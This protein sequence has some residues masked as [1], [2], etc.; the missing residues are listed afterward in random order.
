MPTTTNKA[1]ALLM[2]SGYSGGNVTAYLRREGDCSSTVSGYIGHDWTDDIGPD[3]FGLDAR[4]MSDNDRIDL[5]IGGPMPNV[6]LPPGTMS[7]P[8]EGGYKPYNGAAR[9]LDYVSLDV[10]LSLWEAKGAIVH[11]EPAAVRQ[12][13]ESLSRRG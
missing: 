5:A 11:R 13:A 7:C 10:Y 9:S 8:F 2:V 12:F 4:Q 6:D 1:A 3:T